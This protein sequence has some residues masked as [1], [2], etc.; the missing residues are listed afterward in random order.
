MGVS[1]ALVVEA[2]LNGVV[3]GGVYGLMAS[4]LS[5]TWNVIKVPNSAQGVLVILGSFISYWLFVLYG[6]SPFVLVI[7]MG[8]LFVIGVTLRKFLFSRLMASPP[9]MNFLLGYMIAIV[10]ENLMVMF[11]GAEYKSIPVTYE[12]LRVSAI[13]LPLIRV[14][15]FFISLL[16]FF[17]FYLFLKRTYLGKAMRAV[18]E[19]R[20]AAMLMGIDVERV[21]NIC[22]GIGASLAGIAG[23]LI[24]SMYAFNPASQSLWIGKMFAIVMLGGL[25]NVHAT[26][27]AGI[28][29]GVLEALV[30][31]FMPLMVSYILC[32]VLLLVTLLIRFWK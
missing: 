2:L 5:F 21:S 26:L 19:D 1:F 4:G 7:P 30:G 23:P 12:S 16:V 22:M 11:W 20:D 25:K 8:V 28:V 3:L 10:M 9:M 31:V 6:V 18:G 27:A 13:N 17:F 15:S 32:Y 29:L 24:G 14:I